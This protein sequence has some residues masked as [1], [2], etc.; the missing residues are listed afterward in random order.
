MKKNVH[1]YLYFILLSYLAAGLFLAPSIGIIAVICMLGPVLLAP[2]AG[3]KWCG[4]FCPRGSFEDHIL[5]KFSRNKNIPAFLK[6][7]YIRL[8]MVLLIMTVFSAG[9]YSAAGNIEAVGMVFLRII[10][11]T[12][13]AGVILGYF[14][15]HRTWCAICPMGTLAGLLS[16]FS[17]KPVMVTESCNNCGTCA[18]ICPMEHS[19]QKALSG[20][21]NHPDC[22]KCGMCIDK[23]RKK[24]LSFY[25]RLK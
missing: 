7:G 25:G 16:R 12:T 4:N 10:L 22:I 5:S 14:F 23:C 20:E 18:R 24:A 6:S 21:F 19:P 8:F 13:I 1:K 11:I 2:F 17:M 15:R 9:V 3:R